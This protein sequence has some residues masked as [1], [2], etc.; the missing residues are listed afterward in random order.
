VYAVSEIRRPF[1]AAS[2]ARG[3]AA[4][5]VPAAADFSNIAHHIADALPSRRQGPN[6]NDE[7]VRTPSNHCELRGLG[8]VSYF[9]VPNR[10]FLGS[11]RNFTQSPVY[12]NPKLVTIPLF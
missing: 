1:E 5:H 8:F 4:G 6:E 9:R 7:D 2:L 3:H 11:F 12:E 10:P